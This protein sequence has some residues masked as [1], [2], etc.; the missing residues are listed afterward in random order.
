[1]SA[2]SPGPSCWGS[3]P[4]LFMLPCPCCMAV[5]ARGRPRTAAPAELLQGRAAWG[6]SEPVTF[7]ESF[8]TLD[9]PCCMH[10]RLRHGQGR[11]MTCLMTVLW[12]EQPAVS[13]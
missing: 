3:W 13:L 1:M 9:H 7:A 2:W 5:L 6:C 11:G 4:R 10:V 8:Q 12:R